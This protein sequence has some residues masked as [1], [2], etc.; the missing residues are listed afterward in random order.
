MFSNAH[1]RHSSVVVSGDDSGSSGGSGVH[2]SIRDTGLPVYHAVTLAYA[3]CY[4]HFAIGNAY[5]AM[6][7]QN[8]ISKTLS[9]PLGQLPLSK[10]P[11]VHQPLLREVNVLHRSHVLRRWLADT[12]SNNNGVGLEDDS[13][14]YQL[15]DGERLTTSVMRSGAV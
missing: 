14:V 11:H 3:D 6:P 5:N 4:A 12:R 10:V 1:I 13:I 7:V 9:Y 2:I 8:S 15:I